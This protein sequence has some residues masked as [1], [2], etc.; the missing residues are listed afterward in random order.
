M[1][2][3]REPH[4][5]QLHQPG[6]LADLL[7]DL[8]PQIA[9]LQLRKCG[10][11][12]ESVRGILPALTRYLLTGQGG[13]SLR[14]FWHDSQKPRHVRSSY[15]SR[16][17]SRHSQRAPDGLNNLWHHVHTRIKPSKLIVENLPNEF[18]MTKDSAC[19]AHRD[20]RRLVFK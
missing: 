12:I 19:H 5:T 10:I 14:L 4:L 1:R 16:R 20:S 13:F 7:Y 18:R 11:L 9:L 6:S 2:H 8:W 15:S 17:S 3:H